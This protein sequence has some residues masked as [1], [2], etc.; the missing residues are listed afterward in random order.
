M[1]PNPL[2][3]W[4]LRVGTFRVYYDVIGDPEPT[5]AIKAIARKDRGKIYIGGQ[6]VEL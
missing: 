2:A 4:E 3:R 1:E 5:V 6:E